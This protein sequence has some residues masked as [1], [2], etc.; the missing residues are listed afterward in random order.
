VTRRSGGKIIVVMA[1]H[2][3]AHLIRVALE[4]LHA[5]TLLP[6]EVIVVADRCLDETAAIAR[7]LGATVIETVDNVDAK[8]GALNAVLDDL[9]PRLT[10]DDAVLMMDADSSILPEFLAEASERLAEP[11]RGDLSVGGVGDIFLGCLHSG[12]WTSPRWN[13]NSCSSAP[14]L[15]RE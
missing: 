10:L 6:D 7:A 11:F 5:Q 1:A 8:A 12:P 15:V 14:M 4:S 2:N 3:E 13:A 9:M